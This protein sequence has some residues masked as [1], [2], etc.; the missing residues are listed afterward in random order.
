RRGGGLQRHSAGG[1]TAPSVDQRAVAHARDGQA[2]ARTARRHPRRPGATIRA[3]GTITGRAGLDP[4]LNTVAMVDEY[5]IVVVPTIVGG[6]TPFF[7]TLSSWISSRL[8]E[9]RTFPGGVV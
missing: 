6:G 4:A 2:C 8:V 7:P 9:N 3:I 1:R 5:R